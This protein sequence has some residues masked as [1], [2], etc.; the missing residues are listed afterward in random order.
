MF[1]FE[2]AK[3]LVT[4]LQQ[5]VK[6]YM[7]QG[8]PE[9]D[10]EAAVLER[11]SVTASWLAAGAEKNQTEFYNPH[12][13][14]VYLYSALSVSS[15]SLNVAVEHGQIH[16]KLSESGRKCLDLLDQLQET[17]TKT[18]NL[19]WL[20]DVLVNLACWVE[21]TRP[22]ISYYIVSQVNIQL[23]IP[24]LI[25]PDMRQ[26]YSA[27]LVV[28]ISSW[29]RM[30]HQ[31]HK[32]FHRL[33]RQIENVEDL[34]RQYVARYN[35]V[36]AKLL[37]SCHQYINALSW[38]REALRYSKD[39]EERREIKQLVSHLESTIP[40]GADAD[41]ASIPR[42]AGS[43]TSLNGLIPQP[44][45]GPFGANELLQAGSELQNENR[46]REIDEDWL[47][48]TNI[49]KSEVGSKKRICLSVLSRKA[50]QQGNGGL[51]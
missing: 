47:T 10:L 49:T 28:V 3:I 13:T 31:G 18:Q 39:E 5:H 16:Y 29:L 24:H 38:A 30:G 25:I 36:Y 42:R 8:C 9:A 21:L 4:N 7:A 14:V 15:L 1:D 12:Q 20:A 48:D 51:L 46:E 27:A 19:I 6:H 32:E 33:L 17:K 23:I 2:A 41:P 40:Q 22:H 26:L 44:E 37:Y 50:L 35:I 11:A 45:R 34:P 43:V